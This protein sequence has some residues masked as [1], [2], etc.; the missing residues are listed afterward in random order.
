MLA[1]Q[2]PSRAPRHRAPGRQPTWPA[3]TPESQSGSGRRQESRHPPPCHRTPRQ[4]PACSKRSGL[5]HA[6][7]HSSSA[8]RGGRVNAIGTPQ[9][10]RTVREG[11]G[12]R[13]HE[14]SWMEMHSLNACACTCATHARPTPR[15]DVLCAGETKW[16]RGGRHSSALAPRTERR[17]CHACK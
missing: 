3:P 8:H 15:A 14:G 12:K 13:T 6:L 7:V 10:H 5:G 4:H 17:L 11:S 9:V 1:L 16:E 2:W